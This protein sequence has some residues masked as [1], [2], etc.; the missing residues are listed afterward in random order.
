MPRLESADPG[1]SRWAG[2][3][4]LLQQ[5]AFLEMGEFLQEDTIVHNTSSTPRR[6]LP[7]ARVPGAFGAGR[8]GPGFLQPQPLLPSAPT[9]RR[10]QS[11]KYL[12]DG[13]RDLFRPS[14]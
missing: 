12:A 2:G 6:S 8:M 9:A 4:K 5:A 14:R 1:S 7:D 13:A 3:A 11:T 10:E